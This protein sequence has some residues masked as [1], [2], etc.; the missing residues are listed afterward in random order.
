MTRALDSFSDLLRPHGTT[1]TRRELLSLFGRGAIVSPFAAQELLATGASGH[2]Q[3]QAIAPDERLGTD[4]LLEEIVSR[5][6]QFFW[7][8]AGPHTGLVRDRALA[9]GTPDPRPV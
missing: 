8:E 5:A 3:S 2:Q 1:L 7:N 4:E 9:D 6:F